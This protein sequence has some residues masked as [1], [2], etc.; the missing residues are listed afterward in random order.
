MEPVGSAVSPTAVVF[1]GGF[2]GR[3]VCTALSDAGRQVTAVVRGTPEPALPAGCRTVL[4]D[5]LH[6]DPDVIR[7]ELADLRPGVVVNTVGALW[8]VDETELAEANV[9]FVERLVGAVSA[10]P[11]RVRLVHIGSAYEYGPHPGRRELAETLPGRPVSGYARSKLAGTRIITDAVDAGRIDA[12]VLRIG[13]AVGPHASRHSLL[14]GIARDLAGRPDEVRLPPISGVR[15]IVD[16]RD[17]AAAVLDAA[18]AHRVPPV[19]NIG[20]GTGVRLVDA[21]DTLFRVAGAGPAVSTAARGPEPS[22]RRDA[23]I[24]E[25]PLDIGLARRELG[26][27]PARTL[28]EALRGLW[29]SVGGPTT[30]SP[31]TVAVDGES[32]HG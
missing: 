4:L 10:L 8:G 14:G 28:T 9:T 18:R 26:W 6:T 30:A 1:G 32:I 12:V 17:V 27:V 15:D 5:V 25:Q 19:V 7:A 20:S 23:G 13:L 3:A 21:V 29:D 31:S 11:G 24:G 22:E 16:V 2:V